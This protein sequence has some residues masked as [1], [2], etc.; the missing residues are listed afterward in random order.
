MIYVFNEK[1]INMWQC[2]R[3]LYNNH[4]LIYP[5]LYISRDEIISIND[6]IFEI[7]GIDD[8]YNVYT[9]HKNNNQQIF[10]VPAFVQM[11]QSSDTKYI[12]N[13]HANNISKNISLMS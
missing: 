12:C 5:D 7:T 3:S 6:V 10:P 11:L 8:D 13:N 9:I 1:H 4:I 2:L